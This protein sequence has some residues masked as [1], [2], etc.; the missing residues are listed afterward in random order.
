MLRGFSILEP[1]LDAHQMPQVHGRK[2][3]EALCL[4]P[5]T[6]HELLVCT[7]ERTDCRPRIGNC[8]RHTP[9]V[10]PLDLGC[11]P[12]WKTTSEGR[13]RHHGV[14]RV[15]LQIMQLA[16]LSL[17]CSVLTTRLCLRFGGRVCSIDRIVNINC[18]RISKDLHRHLRRSGLFGR[19]L[20]VRDHAALPFS[21]SATLVPSLV[22]LSTVE[23]QLQGVRVDITRLT[24]ARDARIR[25]DS[26]RHNVR[27][28]LQRL[29][30]SI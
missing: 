15:G 4:P 3:A 24:T 22:F 14:E 28:T 19:L 5:T 9:R 8:G 17:T 16:R 11:S 26:A 12:V 10:Q 23:H 2:F 27:S 29:P 18:R 25:S 30:K 6:T 21:T 20:L 13:E 1:E 7:A